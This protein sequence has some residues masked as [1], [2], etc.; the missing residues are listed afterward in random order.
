MRSTGCE[1][2]AA[3]PMVLHSPQFGECRLAV[4]GECR[5]ERRVGEGTR[6]WIRGWVTSAFA[7][8]AH[9]GLRPGFRCGR[10]FLLHCRRRYIHRL[11]RRRRDGAFFAI[12]HVL[13]AL[14]RRFPSRRSHH[15]FPPLS[16][17]IQS[18]GPAPASTTGGSVINFNCSEFSVLQQFQR[19]AGS[20]PPL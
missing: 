4:L 3:P 2:V 18:S 6:F 13:H 8:V 10:R 16:R 11:R 1:H 12:A 15:L 17:P 14:L 9:A 7:P 5:S 20:S 19:P